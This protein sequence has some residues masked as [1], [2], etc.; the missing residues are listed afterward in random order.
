MMDKRILDL[1]A[2]FTKW[3]GDVYKLAIQIVEIQRE[4]DRE[5]L[6]TDF[7]EAAEVI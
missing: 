2:D 5:K 1:I 6:A 3:R 7:P 4:V